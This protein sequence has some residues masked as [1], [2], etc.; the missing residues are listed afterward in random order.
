MNLPGDMA[1]HPLVIDSALGCRRLCVVCLVGK[2]DCF[3][4]V[5][6]EAFGLQVPQAGERRVRK[7]ALRGHA[8]KAVVDARV[9]E[10]HG[11][12]QAQ[13]EDERRDGPAT[14]V[15]FRLSKLPIQLYSSRP[16]SS[17]VAGC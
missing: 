12:S 17:P 15:A 5:V 9:L 4:E 16:V 14:D 1:T 10:S 13:H 8:E 2:D 6:D 3:L 7:V 11:V